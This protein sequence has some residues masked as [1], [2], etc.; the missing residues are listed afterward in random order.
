M[1]A[2][3]VDIRELRHLAANLQ[4][5]ESRHFLEFVGLAVGLKEVLRIQVESLAELEVLYRY[6]GGNSLSIEL[7]RRKLVVVA[8]NSLGEEY[9][10]WEPAE[11][12]RPGKRIAYVACRKGAALAA[13]EAEDAEDQ[14]QLGELLGY[15]TC[16][17]QHYLKSDEPEAWAGVLIRGLREDLAGYWQCNRLAY[18]LAEAAITP[19]YFPCSLRCQ[20]TRRLG[21]EYAASM[22]RLGFSSLVDGSEACMR[23]SVVVSESR[24]AMLAPGQLVSDIEWDALASHPFHWEQIEPLPDVQRVVRFE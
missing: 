2:Y 13:A 4:W 16:C 8:S 11:D 12:P 1:H 23:R 9:V 7:S 17:V 3:S 14:A 6:I 19:D 21:S 22:S 10:R 24:M 15:P 18:V 5:V 20:S